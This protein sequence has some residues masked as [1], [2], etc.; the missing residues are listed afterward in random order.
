MHIYCFYFHYTFYFNLSYFISFIYFLLPISMR[1][2]RSVGT[3]LT[4]ALM[5]YINKEF[6][7]T[8]ILSVVNFECFI[9][10]IPDRNCDKDKEI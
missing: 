7:I 9:F 6:T 1:Y 10:I 8:Y 3:P 4:R 5:K 2:I